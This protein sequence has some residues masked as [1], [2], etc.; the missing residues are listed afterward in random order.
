L[1]SSP[2]GLLSGTTTQTTP[3]R[4]GQYAATIAAGAALSKT[5]TRNVRAGNYIF[6]AWV[7]TS[8][9]GTISISIVGG[10]VTQTGSFSYANTLGTPA[11]Y[12]TGWQYCE[13]KVPLTGITS[14]T[15]SVS[16][17]C[18]TAATIDDVWFYPD[19]AELTTFGYDPIAFF[20]TSATNTNGVAAYYGYDKFGRLLYTYNQDKN[21]TSCKIYASQANEA[22]FTCPAISGS[23]TAYRNVWGSWGFVTN[24]AYNACVY[25]SGVTFT[26]DFGD[27]TAPVTTSSYIA[28]N[29]QYTAT[30]TYTIVLTASS[31]VYGSKSSTLTVTVS[32][33]TQVVLHY[34]NTTTS[35]INTV[36][37]KQG[38]TT[39]YTISGSSLN[40]AV[41]APGA[42][43]VV[44][45]P[46]GSTYNS[47]SLSASDD[48]YQCFTRA[49]ADFTVS[50][51]DLTYEPNAYFTMSTSACGGGGGQ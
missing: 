9:A 1:G 18:S 42:Y 28:Q 45:H 49:G 39:V 11:T 50:S 22:N 2:Y 33:L 40:G 12:P 44:I 4:S 27:G 48:F 3:G 36:Y 47:V 37:F 30:G 31:P 51:V 6:S 34:T 10:G 26:W 16:A 14:S 13:V 38:G 24:P 46:T 41:I 21:I 8:A 17:S 35:A 5:I 15:I 25:A 32:N 43:T 7:K 29:H 20:K 23:A 19:V